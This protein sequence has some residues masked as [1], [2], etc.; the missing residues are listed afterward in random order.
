MRALRTHRR[1]EEGVVLGTVPRTGADRKAGRMVARTLE[2]D[3][4]TLV[5][6][7]GGSSHP[8]QG[9]VLQDKGV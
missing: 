8:G 3:L 5:E 6:A 1:V 9:E 2:E 7:A 4:G